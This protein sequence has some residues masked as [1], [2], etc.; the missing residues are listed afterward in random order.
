MT[1]T[2]ML[3]RNVSDLQEQLQK[4]Y[5]RIKDLNEEVNKLNKLLGKVK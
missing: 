1:E 5:T 3:K 2:E 4:S